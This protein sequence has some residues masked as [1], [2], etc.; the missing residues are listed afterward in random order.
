MS[1]RQ[2]LVFRDAPEIRDRA[3]SSFQAYSKPSCPVCS[4][5]IMISRLRIESYIFCYIVFRKGV[6]IATIESYQVLGRKICS[7]IDTSEIPSVFLDRHPFLNLGKHF[8]CE[9]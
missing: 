9:N 3:R 8:A 2:V 1:E 7:I 4:S 6:V 5:G